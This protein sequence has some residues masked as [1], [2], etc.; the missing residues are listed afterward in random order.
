MP[1]YAMTSS[2]FQN[3]LMKS[4]WLIKELPETDFARFFSKAVECPKTLRY[5]VDKLLMILSDLLNRH[6]V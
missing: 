1:V 4:A 5:S 3:D 6:Q 2:E